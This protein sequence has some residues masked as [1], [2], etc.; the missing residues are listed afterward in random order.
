M[1]RVFNPM[2]F[3]TDTSLSY[4]AKKAL[5]NYQSVFE[6]LPDKDA[7]REHLH[8]F[9]KLRGIGPKI[10]AE[11]SKW[12]GA[13]LPRCPHCGRLLVEEAGEPLRNDPRV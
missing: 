1:T 13:D 4:H 3:F 11:L 7:V 5:R 2:D 12:C 6:D 10:M 8:A 9:S